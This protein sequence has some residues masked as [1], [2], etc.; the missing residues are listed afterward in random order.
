[1]LGITQT[2][3]LV[4]G[5]ALALAALLRLQMLWSPLVWLRLGLE[6]IGLPGLLP[7]VLGTMGYA[8]LYSGGAFGHGRAVRAAVLGSIVASL[9]AALAIFVPVDVNDIGSAP[10]RAVA[11]TGEGL[12][13]ASL[14]LLVAAAVLVT[15]A[16]DVTPAARLGLHA[17]AVVA[18]FSAAFELV[19][20]W[21][22]LSVSNDLFQSTAFVA[23]GEAMLVALARLAIGLW[24]AWPWLGPRV[25][26]ARRALGRAAAA[27]RDSTP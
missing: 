16:P 10:Q 3:A 20:V 22:G 5:G 23:S 13:L 6:P 8:V 24:F 12:D 14:V 17:L 18:L 4:G 11:V 21:F 1:M 27:H 7:I 26:S 9:L 15:R 2:T 25:T 19:F